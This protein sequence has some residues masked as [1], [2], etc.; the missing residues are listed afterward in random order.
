VNQLGV[1]Q[2]IGGVNEKIEGWFDV[3]RGKSLTHTQGA[4]CFPCAVMFCGNPL[5]GRS[6]DPSVEYG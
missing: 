5:L 1:V 3:C 4:L 2:P 6:C